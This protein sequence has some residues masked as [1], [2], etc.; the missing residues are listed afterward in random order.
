MLQHFVWRTSTIDNS[1]PLCRQSKRALE[2]A[3]R[4]VNP[5]SRAE[6]YRRLALAETDAARAKILWQLVDEAQ[7]L[8]CIS[9]GSW[10]LPSRPR[11]HR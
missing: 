1:M 5:N 8:L 10:K 9:D 7:R 3:S 4:E 11:L 2:N 6:R